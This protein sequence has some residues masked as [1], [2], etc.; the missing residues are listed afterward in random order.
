VR[1]ARG[2]HIGAAPADLGVSERTISLTEGVVHA[3]VWN[4]LKVWAALTLLAV[5]VIGFGLG[6]WAT[7]A[8]AGSD[9]RKEPAAGPAEP[10]A[11]KPSALVAKER[12]TPAP[13]P[14]AERLAAP[15][16]P[17]AAVPG[18]RREAVIKLPV[19]TF[20]KEVDATPYGSGRIA[21]TYEEDRVLGTI[22]G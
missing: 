22:E 7:A 8:P 4:K 20:V 18:R 9:D 6:R 11:V 12:E 16:V 13:T 21:W 10:G 14:A 5:A 17:K 1:A 19:G 3:M 2:V 15:E